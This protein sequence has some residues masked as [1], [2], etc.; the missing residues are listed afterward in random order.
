MG[1]FLRFFF[2]HSLRRLGTDVADDRLG[3]RTDPMTSAGSALGA[4][5]NNQIFEGSVL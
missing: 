4:C 1:L 3:R 5:P 2:R